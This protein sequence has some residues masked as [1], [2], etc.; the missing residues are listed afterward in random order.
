MRLFFFVFK[1]LFY[2][3]FIYFISDRSRS[4]AAS[5]LSKSFTCLLVL[6][7]RAPIIET[8][9]TRQQKERVELGSCILWSCT[10]VCWSFTRCLA[11]FKAEGAW[12]L[13][14]TPAKPP[15]GSRG[16]GAEGQKSDARS[17]EQPIARNGGD[18]V[19]DAANATIGSTC[20]QVHA[21]AAWLVTFQITM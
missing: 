4:P 13:A 8:L 19:R 5:S 20:T 18:R 12:L 6:C 7:R 21:A 16:G 1:I 11:D 10:V 9:E 3:Y 15:V 2:F 17:A 14:L